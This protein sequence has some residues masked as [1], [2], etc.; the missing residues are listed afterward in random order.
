LRRSA[1][2]TARA[3]LPRQQRFALG[4]GPLLIALI[5]EDGRQHNGTTA[6]VLH[7][8]RRL[9][10]G[11]RLAGHEVTQLGVLAARLGDVAEH[12]DHAEDPPLL[13]AN[14]RGAVVDR[15]LRTIL[16]PE[17]SM[18]GEADDLA[19]AEHLGDRVL[20][21]LAGGLVD[22]VEDLLERAALGV[23]ARPSGE[24]NGHRVHE[25]NTP[26]V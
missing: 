23:F 10:H 25:D 15:D 22:D 6:L 4:L 2:A 7:G 3:L 21:A 12:Q 18:V 11:D 26:H 17:H 20:D 14:R 19:V 13:I 9:R 5:A 24:L 8:K 1:T 16:A